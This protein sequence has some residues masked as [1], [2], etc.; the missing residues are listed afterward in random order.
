M[1]FSTLLRPL[2]VLALA[3]A[4]PAAAE[5]YSYANADGDYVISQA[6]P[7]DGRDYIVLSDDGEF[8]QRV[9]SPALDVPISHWRPWYLPAE[10]NPLDDQEPDPL[11]TP[12]VVVDEVE[13]PTSD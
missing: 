8:I 5:L 10:P 4:T 3:V 1:P 9:Q 13:Q 12:S 7:D 2:L 11:P 6:R